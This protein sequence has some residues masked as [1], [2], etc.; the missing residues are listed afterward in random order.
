MKTTELVALGDFTVAV[1]GEERELTGIY[2]ADLLSWA[3]GRAPAGCAWCTVM[4]NVNALAVASLAEVAAL[5][6][7]EGVELDAAAQ[8]RATSEGIHVVCTK[9]PV[10][11]AGLAI[12]KAAGLAGL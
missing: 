7:C 10:F 4:G 6:L 1:Q 12:A 11:E 2:C 5:V 8:A 9:L 3:M